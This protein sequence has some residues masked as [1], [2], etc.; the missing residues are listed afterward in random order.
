[1]RAF[2]IHFFCVGR[3][4]VTGDVAHNVQHTSVGVNS[5]CHILG[6]LGIL[7]FVG[8]VT[9][10][11]FHDAVHQRTVLQFKFYFGNVCI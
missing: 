10:F 3:N 8:K 5:V 11:Q 9:F 1:M 7:V 2:R 6:S 4:D